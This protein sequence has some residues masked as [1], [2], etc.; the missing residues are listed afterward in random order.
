M[1]E[2]QGDHGRLV[3]RLFYFAIANLG[4]VDVYIPKHQKVG[5]FGNT[6]HGIVHIQDDTYSYPSGKQANKSDSS[7]GPVHYKPIPDR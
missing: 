5:N 7:L 6:Q 2:V 3:S 4:R 1:N